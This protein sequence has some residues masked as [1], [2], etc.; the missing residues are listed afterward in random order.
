MNKYYLTS[1]GQAAWNWLKIYALILVACIIIAVIAKV[2]SPPFKPPVG[3][4]PSLAGGYIPSIQAIQLR[5]GA[6]PDGRLGPE[7][8]E[9]WDMAYNDQCAGETWPEVGK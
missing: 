1:K 6:D 9:K 5:V 2:F 4:T 8:Q 3:N 7:T